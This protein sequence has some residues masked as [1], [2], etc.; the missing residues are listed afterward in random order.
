MSQ[1][2]VI[3]AACNMPTQPSDIKAT[4]LL[5]NKYEST[6]CS[7]LPKIIDNFVSEEN[8]LVTSQNRRINDSQGHAVYYG[9]GKGDG[10][11][12]VELAKVRAQLKSARAE[13]TKKNCD[14]TKRE[15]K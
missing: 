11:D 13:F 2:A 9:W 6:D 15:G 7:E 5:Q 14:N 3:L 12:T 4:G 1:I 10:M 8:A